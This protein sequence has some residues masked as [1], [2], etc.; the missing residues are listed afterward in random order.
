MRVPDSNDTFYVV[1]G[2]AQF[3]RAYYAIRGGMTSP[4]T[5]EPTQMVFGFVGMLMRL[6]RERAPG[7]LV[8]VIDAAGDQETFR[9]E[10]YPEYKANRDPAPIDFHPQVE[11]CLEF[12][13]LFGVPIFAIPAVEADDVI[14][15]IVRRVQREQ[16]QLRIRIVSRDKDLSQLVDAS[17]SLFDP[18]TGIDLGPEQ[19][20]ETKGVRADQVADMLALMGDSVDNVPG[21]T[22]IGPKTAA[23]LVTTYG[24]LD[25]VLA[26]LE[27]L[28][29]KRRA[30][31]EAARGTLAVARKL[32]ALK[33][34]C[35]IDFSYDAAR[36]DLARARLPE[37]LELLTTLGFGRLK[38]EVESVVGGTRATV[39]STAAPAVAVGPAAPKKPKGASSARFE[40][41]PLFAA[42][43]TEGE[44]PGGIGGIAADHPVH[45]ANYRCL[46]T[47]GEISAFVDEA[48]QAANRGERIAFD[49]ET[50][51]LNTVV[52]R[53]CGLSFSFREGEGVY[54][55]VRSPEAETHA[56]TEEALAI[57]SPLFD[58]PSIPKVAH[59]AK[60][61]LEVLAR[62]GVR[63]RGLV[64][65][66]MIA[67]YVLDATRVSHS[68]DSL[69][70][71]M[72]AY[73][74]VPITD[75]IGRGD[76][77]RTFDQVALAK[78]TPYA[79][80]DAD[81]AHRLDD[82]LTKRLD[83]AG[84]GRLYREIEMP[85][86]E[87]LA[88]M[89]MNGV[90]VDRKELEDQCARLSKE[91]DA[92]RDALIASAPHPFNPDSPKQLAAVLFNSPEANPPGLGLK[93][94]RRGTE[95][96]STSVDVLE[97][98]AGDPSV[99]SDIPG[100]MIE[101]RR[102]RKLVGTYLV[103]L[104]EAIQPPTGRI[105]AS[106][107]Q[108]GTATGRLSSSEPNMQNI[109]IR[110]EV[111]REIRRAF[112]APPGFHLVACDYSQIELRVLAHLADD[113]AMI[114]AFH[115]GVDIHVA[116][117][118]QVHGIEPEDVTPTQ[119]S[120][121][122]MV[123]FGIVYGITAYGLARRLGGGTT[124]QRAK[125]I[126]DSYRAR[127]PGIAAFLGR[128]IEQAKTHGFVET[129]MGRRR[130][131]PQIASRNPAERALGERI[132]INTVVQGTAADLIKMAMVSIHRALPG[133]FP[134][135][136]MLLQIHDELVF[137][138]PI[139]EVP[140]ATAWI[141]ARMEQV[142]TMK[143]PLVATSASG[144]NWYDA[145]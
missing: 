14:A 42:L 92:F 106:F 63:V 80:E 1:D 100:K 9:S 26:N 135:A 67:S 39:A 140:S 50:D 82:L 5:N 36:V 15:T 65:D 81:I 47:V 120:A 145:K 142:A 129:M 45:Q 84:L 22:G 44:V 58:D 49:T 143:V 128:C 123:N 97:R 130:P 68:L 10:L 70:Q 18:Q 137:E 131:V 127:Y 83:D 32:V 108:T 35:E 133:S 23:Q 87:V 118:A 98:L 28:T 29:P 66:S 38:G 3:F 114:A 6:I 21:V 105:H 119:R 86:V 13:R 104:R 122:K 85:L 91:T 76:F 62:H 116:V 27:A 7:H 124:P 102:L 134:K 59:N 141:R 2:H 61:D 88:T 55:P 136:K 99:E 20:F 16:P 19:L 95:T 43:D 111:G 110:T 52:A 12:T 41:A 33:E 96:P 48:R 74:P 125:E 56:T 34:D 69:S 109:P 60:F 75:L 57:L 115:A 78:A 30:A 71:A 31:I 113:S 117:A 40:D 79:A 73:T 77:Q 94:V 121:A 93:S 107:H 53:L 112:V 90:L 54:I 8:L 101:Y 37:L 11:R 89:E 64:G 126:I 139:D 144:A 17:T 132:A 72:L 51:S 103:A 25:G 4:T 138:V 46:K 24:S